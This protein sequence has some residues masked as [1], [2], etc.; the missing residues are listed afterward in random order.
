MDDAPLLFG[1]VETSEVVGLRA[2]EVSVG[3]PVFEAGGMD[4]RANGTSIPV[5][6]LQNCQ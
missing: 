5:L 3:L 2:S 6:R 4:L 1:V